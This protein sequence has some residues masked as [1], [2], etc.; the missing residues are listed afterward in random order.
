MRAQHVDRAEGL[1]RGLDIR[2][3]T[4]RRTATANR[5]RRI[6]TP[7]GSSHRRRT[8][9]GDR[10]SISRVFLGVQGP[11]TFRGATDRPGPRATSTLPSITR[12]SP[13]GLDNPTVPIPT[14]SSESRR[15]GTEHPPR[16]LRCTRAGRRSRRESAS[17]M[18][19]SDRSAPK[20]RAENAARRIVIVDVVGASRRGP[21]AGRRCRQPGP[22]RRCCRG[23]RRRRGCAPGRVM[24]CW[25]SPNGRAAGATP[26]SSLR[27]PVAVAVADCRVLVPD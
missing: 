18:N 21:A 1:D 5:P 23:R 10:R 16:A 15:R 27:P 2:S 24:A 9:T 3:P 7:D 20:T 22:D 25:Y 6:A 8:R 14:M 17:R 11:Q 12:C 4:G 26:D 13:V 19:G